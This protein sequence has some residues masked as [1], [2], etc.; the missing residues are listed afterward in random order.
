LSSAQSACGFI[1]SG[2]PVTQGQ[3]HKL[4]SSAEIILIGTPDREIA[5]AE[6]AVAET[7]TRANVV[8]H[9]S[10]ALPSSVLQ[11]C[12]SKG[13]AAGSMHPLQSFAD[14]EAA[15]HLVKGAL[16]ACEGDDRAVTA[17][18][19]IAQ[20][21]GGRPTQI[22]TASKAV[23]HAAASAAS[24]FMIVPLLLSMDLMEAAGLDKR[25][26]LSALGPLVL[27]T[28]KNAVTMGVPEAL[29]GP[30]ER[31]DQAI[32]EGHIKAIDQSCPHLKPLYLE[33]ARRTAEAAQ[34]KGTLSTSA[35]LEMQML[36]KKHR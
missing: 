20:S 32:V 27:G 21:V 19:R 8:L 2:L 31:N 25:T 10:G 14:P 6:A 7:V 26:G 34:R 17:A 23:Y 28:A 3:A 1:G 12:R 22:E 11:Q 30:I 13:A 16:F 4:A 35:V 33:L 18:F 24:N 36:F 9:F 5:R 15:L 29:T